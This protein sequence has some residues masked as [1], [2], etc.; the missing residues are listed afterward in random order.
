M[1]FD[2]KL[3]EIDSFIYK[4]E[5][6]NGLTE[7]EYDHIFTGKFDGK[8]SL[9]TEEADDYKWIDLNSLKKEIKKKP[10]DFTVWFKIAME[11]IF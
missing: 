4:A 2:C 5:F 11:K 9:N 7:H 10:E 6:D 8:P 3:K 1:G